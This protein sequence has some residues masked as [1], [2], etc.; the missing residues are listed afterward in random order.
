MFRSVFP[1]YFQK[2]KYITLKTMFS[3]KKKQRGL[4][5]ANIK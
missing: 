3:G 4:G 1:K 2:Q 5:A